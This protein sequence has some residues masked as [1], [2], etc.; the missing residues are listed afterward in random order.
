MADLIYDGTVW[1]RTNERTWVIIQQS[2]TGT[3]FRIA[4]LPRFDYIY[5]S[6]LN[7]AI[8]IALQLWQQIQ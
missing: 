4:A 2:I 7:D 1:D 5:T 8:T 6:N 3:A